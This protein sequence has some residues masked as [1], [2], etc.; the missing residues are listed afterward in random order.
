MM[1]NYIRSNQLALL[2]TLFTMVYMDSSKY[3]D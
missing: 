3:I 1:Y 2:T